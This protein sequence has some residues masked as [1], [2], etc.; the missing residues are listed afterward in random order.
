MRNIFKIIPIVFFICFNLNAGFGQ[1][2][3]LSNSIKNSEQLFYK[4][5]YGW[6]TIGKGYV[7][8]REI[9]SSKLGVEAE[10][11]TVGLLGVFANLEDFFSS[12][13]DKSSL[14]P[15]RSEKKI[16]DGRYWRE[17]RNQFNY[18]D[19]LVHI[20]IKDFKDS[21]K[22]VNKDVSITKNTLDMLS[23]YLFLRSTDWSSKRLTDSVM[24]S[25]F[26][27][28]KIYNFGVEYG[29]ID[30]T[31]FKSRKIKTHKLYVLFP[32]SKVFPSDK[33]VTVWIT[34]DENQLPLKVVAKLGIGKAVL[35]LYKHKGST[36]YQK[37]GL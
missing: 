9:N 15:I 5:H 21:S 17:Q 28:K 4:I 6:F 32:K 37:Y 3:S 7:E 30:I 14:L 36:K 2:T 34:A 20:E 12:E 18:R 25:T 16:S 33:A 10:G 31:K 35:E 22:N 26:Y 13:I 8:I 11:K 19:S 24:I 27:D 1:E 29:G 23:S